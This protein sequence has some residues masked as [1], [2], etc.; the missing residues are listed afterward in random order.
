MSKSNALEKYV[1]TPPEAEEKVTTSVN[2]E[3]RQLKFVQDYNLNLSS[4]VRDKL[5]E[6]MKEQGVK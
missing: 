6:M 2:V 4:I 1:K 5:A 3:K